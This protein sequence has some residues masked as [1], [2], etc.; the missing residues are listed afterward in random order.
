MQTADA[1]S[2]AT[3]AD[4]QPGDD[5]IVTTSLPGNLREPICYLSDDENFYLSMSVSCHYQRLTE[6]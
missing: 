5:V 6:C 4:W 1:F 2:I 3:P